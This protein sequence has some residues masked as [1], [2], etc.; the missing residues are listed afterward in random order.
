M[1][2]IYLFAV[3][4]FVNIFS[5]CKK[6]TTPEPE[7]DVAE[8]VYVGSVNHKLYAWDAATGLKRWDFVT[9]G[10]IL[11]SPSVANG[12]VYLGSNDKK[13]YA[14]D[15]VTGAKKMGVCY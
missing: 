11:S 8:T 9:G 3:L 12:V 10:E 1:K 13:L 2:F 7:L 5:S 14:L 6:K 4:L 15:A